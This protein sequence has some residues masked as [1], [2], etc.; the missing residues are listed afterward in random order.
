MNIGEKVKSL[1]SQ[2][3]MTLKDLATQAD[4]SV[5]FL[6]QFER[7][8]TTIDVAHLQTIADIFGVSIQIFFATKEVQ[9][10][11]VIRSYERKDQRRLNNAIY[12]S[13]SAES[14]DLTMRPELL[15]L[16][17]DE[18]QELPEAYTHEGE[19][20]VYVLAGILTL[21]IKDKVYQLYPGDA[22]HFNSMRLHN[23]ANQGQ[24]LVKLL[25]VH[26]GNLG[27]HDHY[28]SQATA[29]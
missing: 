24:S 10:R 2:H 28:E 17:P 19:E 5:G 27:G 21:V 22:T 23:W 8:M 20:F 14:A 15:I 26:S 18:K 16:L 7:G 11:D 4:L 1:R 12:E 3:K 6:S 29:H 25:V 13:L 9:K